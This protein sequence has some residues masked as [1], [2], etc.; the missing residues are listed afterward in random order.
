MAWA[1]RL[2]VLAIV[3]AYGGSA[4]AQ[5][6]TATVG[7]PTPLMSPNPVFEVSGFVVEYLRPNEAAPPVEELTRVP[8]ALSWLPTGFTAPS[9]GLAA[10]S[11]PL[12]G[13]SNSE[14]QPYHATALQAIFQALQQHLSDAG[15]LGVYVA[16]DPEQITEDGQDVR[17]H[18][19]TDL[20]ILVALGQVTRVRTLAQGDRVKA[21]ERVDN[22][23]HKRIAEKSPVQP[24]VD[25]AL[26]RMDLIR[27]N[28]LDNYVLRLSRH[29][30][31]RVDVALSAAPEIGG[32]TLDYLVTEVKPW[33]VYAQISNTGTRDTSRLREQFGL[34]HYQLTG[35]D[36]VFGVDYSTANFDEA[37]SISIDYD[38]RFFD[39]DRL[40][41]RVY[42]GWDRYTASDI[43][44]FGE[45]FT[46]ETWNAGGEFLANVYQ[47]GPF[48]VD[49][50]PGVRFDHLRVEQSGA[51]TGEESFLIPY[52]TVRT[53]RATDW[54]L[55]DSAV[56]LEYQQPALTGVDGDDLD[57]L[58]R[59]EVDD[60]WLVLHG[61]VSQS[62]FL[63]PLL[64]LRGWRNA[65]E[66]RDS[67]LA[68][69]LYFSLRGQHAFDQRLIPQYEA[70]A[71][72]LYSVRGYAESAT[73]GDNAVIGTAEYRY[74]LPKA[75][76][77]EREPRQIAARPF[78]LAPQHVFGP[79]DWDLILRAFLDGGYVTRNDSDSF[80]DDSD[81]LLGTGLGAELQVKRN[82]TLRLD[83]GVALKDAAETAAGSQQLHFV[84]TVLY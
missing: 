16:P 40:R 14:P 30:G 8:I 66:P 12:T 35:N 32:V 59:P 81:T 84:I 2:S 61:N 50:G 33:L 38:A 77:L 36:D 82:L 70:V 21:S 17:P 47:N 71:G 27:K 49:L 20:R 75:L 11:R 34:R 51:P 60:Q 56:T 13:W 55:F 80:G 22:L 3:M 65:E 63:E 5:A 68:H 29:P 18:G 52:F 48:F 54:N 7:P 19:Q 25:G 57:L 10:A 1:A 28:E 62:F 9:S 15:Y 67:T 37:H 41:W 73:A 53:T 45:D 26:K 69:E 76:P 79:T 42:G 44:L 58:G 4:W 43:G 74:H 46:G 39:Y 23:A 64:N 24:Y 31:R 83:W 6:T 78:R 72:G